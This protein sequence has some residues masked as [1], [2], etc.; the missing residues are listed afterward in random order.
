L[1]LAPHLAEFLRPLL[2]AVI[3]L[4]LT[5]DRWERAFSVRTRPW[6]PP[7]GSHSPPLA[8]KASKRPMQLILADEPLFFSPL[9]C[10]SPC[11]CSGHRHRPG[12]PGWPVYRPSVCYAPF[13]GGA[14]GRLGAQTKASTQRPRH[15][16]WYKRKRQSCAWNGVDTAIVPTRRVSRRQLRECRPEMAWTRRHSGVRC[17]SAAVP[18]AAHRWPNGFVTDHAAP[19]QR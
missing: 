6:R 9:H 3:R 4:L 2:P 15:K 14:R 8:A 13:W 12:F 1:K 10:L 19:S 5:P 18:L 11:A 17:P 16:R 7:V